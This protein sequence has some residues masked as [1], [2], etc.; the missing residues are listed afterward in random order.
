MSQLKKLAGQTAIYGISSILGKTINF[1]LIPIYTAYLPKEDVGAFTVIYS[2]IAFFNIIFTYGMETAFF[3][4]STGKGLEAQRVYGNTQSLIITTSL[5]LGALLYVSASPL[6]EML[7]YDGKAYLFRW[8]ALI[9]TI[10]AVMA[11]PFAKLRVEGKAW[12]FAL[13]KLLNILLNVGFNIFFIVFCYHVYSGDLFPSLQPA[14]AYFYRPDW[15]VDY[16]LLSN[17]LANA[18]ILPFLFYLT[19]K[20][21]FAL[22][23]NVLKPM[24]HY[25]VPLLFMGLAG[26]TNEVFSRGLFEYALPEGFYEGLSKREAGGVFGANFRLAILMNLII[27][28]FKYA[29]EPF[30]FQQAANKNNP[31]IFAKVMHW[32]ILFCSL[33]MVAVTVNLDIIGPLFLRGEGYEKALNIVP[34]LLLGYLFLG[35]YYN[36]SIWFKIT[37]KTKYSF[38][39]TLI[40]AVI[41]VLVIFMLIPILGFMGAALSTLFTY[42]VMAVLCYIIGQK[43]YPVPY[44]TTKGIFYLSTAFLLGYL[45]F[46][47]ELKNPLWEF[48]VQNTFLLAYALMIVLMEK[49]ELYLIFQ[50]IFAKRDHASKSN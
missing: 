28:A 4:F 25:A 19:G 43:Y 36:L 16:I 10:D 21:T 42:M 20:F 38:Y 48:L 40:G 13:T 15:G 49:K 1:L 31:A 45:G 27:Q 26:V 50:S 39:I 18:L 6:S 32:F 7:G 17:L 24:W 41:T 3:R 44:Q 12:A 37:D 47:V 22:D 9:L 14:V 8:V 33:L 11:I 35:I 23:K 5:S 2:F 29:A 30:F 46:V 34:V